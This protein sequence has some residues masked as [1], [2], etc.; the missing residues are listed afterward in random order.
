MTI[1][2]KTNESPSPIYKMHSI[3][4]ISKPKSLYNLYTGEDNLYTLFMNPG[5]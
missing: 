3:P 2:P 4:S 1:F 5:V